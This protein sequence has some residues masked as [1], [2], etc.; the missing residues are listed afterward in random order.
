MPFHTL[1]EYA[2]VED[3]TAIRWAVE[4]ANLLAREEEERTTPRWKRLLK[5]ETQC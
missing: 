1:E 4:E 5:R 2:Q 3:S